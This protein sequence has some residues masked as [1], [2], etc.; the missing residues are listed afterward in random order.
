MAYLAYLGT[1][2]LYLQGIAIAILPVGIVDIDIVLLLIACDDCNTCIAI[3]I[4]ISIATIYM[5]IWPY[6]GIVQV[7]YRRFAVLI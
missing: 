7:M 4:S 2:M 1:G 5:A 6:H 3:L